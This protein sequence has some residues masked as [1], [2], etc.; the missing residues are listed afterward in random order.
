MED[1]IILKEYETME[2]CLFTQPETR[3]IKCVTNIDNTAVY[4]KRIVLEHI[5]LS[6]VKYLPKPNDGFYKYINHKFLYINKKGS[7]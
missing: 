1:L 4:N 7:L 2:E 3:K 6:K 5:D